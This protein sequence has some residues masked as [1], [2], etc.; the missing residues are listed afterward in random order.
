MIIFFRDFFKM[1]NN[2]LICYFY[3]FINSF[4]EKVK[5][6]GENA[7]FKKWERCSWK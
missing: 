2:L 5:E 3:V 1:R 4:K 7:V 6:R